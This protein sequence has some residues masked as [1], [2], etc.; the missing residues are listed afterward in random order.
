MK[1]VDYSALH[2]GEINQK[3]TLLLNAVKKKSWTPE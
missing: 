2:G 3:C 1:V